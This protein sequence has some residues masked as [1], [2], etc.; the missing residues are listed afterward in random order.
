MSALVILECNAC[1][2]ITP[3]WPTADRAREE[4]AP[5]GWAVDVD[6]SNI[7]YCPRC[8]APADPVNV[9]PLTAPIVSSRLDI[10]R[11]GV[12]QLRT[13][14]IAIGE[15]LARRLPTPTAAHALVFL[16]VARADQLLAELAAS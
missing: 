12:D 6:G 9:V 15:E 14:L 10:A 16:S 4:V 11:R 5:D 2:A 3:P 7:D 1:G 8:T 13:A